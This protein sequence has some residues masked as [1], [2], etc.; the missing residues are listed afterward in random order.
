MTLKSTR[1][2]SWMK[3]NIVMGVGDTLTSLQQKGEL[4][5]CINL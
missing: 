4:H 2:V 1:M 3:L 5:Y